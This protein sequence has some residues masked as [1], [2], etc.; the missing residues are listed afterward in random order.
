[1]DLSELDLKNFETLEECRD[2]LVEI[3]RDQMATRPHEGT[4][5]VEWLGQ[6]GI[7]GQYEANS[8]IEIQNRGKISY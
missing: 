8:D 3:W 7:K 1:M 2:Y 5:F 4:T 6:Q